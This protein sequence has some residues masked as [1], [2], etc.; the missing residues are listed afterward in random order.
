[1]NASANPGSG[2]RL[3]ARLDR[4]LKAAGVRAGEK[5]DRLIENRARV[6]VDQALREAAG[7]ATVE[8]GFPGSPH[9]TRFAVHNLLEAQTLATT[10]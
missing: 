9:E 4:E 1:M 2:R 3:R 5:I 10:T 7:L 6:I 8:S